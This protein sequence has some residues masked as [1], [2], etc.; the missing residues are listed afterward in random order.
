MMLNVC[1]GGWPTGWKGPTDRM[2]PRSSPALGH[3]PSGQGR[4]L[5]TTETSCTVPLFCAVLVKCCQFVSGSPDLCLDRHGGGGVAV[6]DGAWS[7]GLD[8]YFLRGCDL[9][10][11]EG[12]EG[13]EQLHVRSGR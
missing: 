4:M 2:V 11:R 6:D 3:E 13:G 10:A 12:E 9:E 8:G 1:S 7:W 5:S